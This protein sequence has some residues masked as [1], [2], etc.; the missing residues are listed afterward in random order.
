MAITQKEIDEPYIVRNGYVLL[1]DGSVAQIITDTLSSG[2]N[3]QIEKLNFDTANR[4]RVVADLG[5]AAVLSAGTANIGVVGTHQ[6]L[7]AAMYA[8]TVAT[9]AAGATFTGTSRD[10]QVGAASPVAPFYA[11]GQFQV[12]AISDKTASLYIDESTDG[13][14]WHTV[15]VQ[16]GAAVA[17]YAGSPATLYV[18]SLNYKCTARF[19]RAVLKNTSGDT[20]TI[21]KMW[22][23]VIG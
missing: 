1:S 17:D 5:T 15:Y 20:N 11:F 2:V 7:L 10:T 13:T 23:R 18:A 21:C 19:I 3:R 12:L 4:L 9:L 8:D 16:A 14:N 6:K 22:S